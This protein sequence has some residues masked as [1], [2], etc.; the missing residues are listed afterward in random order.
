MLIEMQEWKAEYEALEAS[1]RRDKLIRKLKN[2]RSGGNS[3]YVWQ[4]DGEHLG[5]V[6]VHW[7]GKKTEPDYPDMM[8]LFVHNDHRRK[9]IASR[10]IAAVED[11]ARKRGFDRIGL[12]VS[13]GGNQPAEKL[14]RKLGYDFTPKP[15]HP[16][17][18][19]GLLV[20]DMEKRLTAG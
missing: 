19:V 3:W 11:E 4:E 20:R 17:G 15:A 18:K 6:I 2:T 12:S 8:K 9:G 7:S 10:M 14:Y 5:W 13:A 1:L 16:M